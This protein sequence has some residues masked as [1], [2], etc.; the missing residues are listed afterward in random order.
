MSFVG[1]SLVLGSP[2]ALVIVEG[3]DVDGEL[4]FVAGFE[5]IGAAVPASAT[6]FW[7]VGNELGSFAKVGMVDR[8]A[9]ILTGARVGS[10]SES[11]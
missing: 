3:S 2:G 11:G 5:Y 6:V 8:V 10:S 9:L 7:M 1:I 4:G